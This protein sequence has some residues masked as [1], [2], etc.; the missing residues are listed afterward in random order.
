MLHRMA[1]DVV[2]LWDTAGI[3]K[4][5]AQAAVRSIQRHAAALG[6][7]ALFKVRPLVPHMIASK[8]LH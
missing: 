1:P 2:V 6:N 3:A 5:S 7:P 4:G 8:L